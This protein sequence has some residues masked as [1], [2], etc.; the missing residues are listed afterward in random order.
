MRTNDNVL[1][2]IY[3]YCRSKINLEIS[4]YGYMYKCKL[5]IAN[6]MFHVKSHTVS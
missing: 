5:T 4:E 3:I 1:I 2:S 6:D